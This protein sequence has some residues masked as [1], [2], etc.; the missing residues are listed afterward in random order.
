MWG[1]DSKGG[2][3]MLSC[4]FGCPNTSRH[5]LCVH[6][7]PYL[8]STSVCPPILYVPQMSWELLGG[9]C[10]PHM[11]WGLCKGISISVRHFCVCQYIHCLTVYNSHTSCSPSLWIASLL[12]WML[13]DVC[14]ASCCCSFLCCVFIMSQASATMAMTTSPLVTIGYSGMSSL[15]SMVTM[16]TFLVGFPVTSG[17]HDVL[18]PLLTLR[19][20]GG[21][22]GL[23]TVP[24]QQP[25]SRI[26][27]QTCANYAM[28]PLQVGFSLRVE[29][30]TIC[31]FICLVSVLM[32]A[33]YFQVLYWMLY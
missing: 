18:S 26:P 13:M 11:S 9:I 1:V 31:I 25:P 14:H 29:P 10:T 12:D 8:P 28:G 3:C 20:S 19:H 4:M 27:L 17:Q 6:M 5:P 30:P 22:D 24:Q 23:A 2:I 16:I 7:P 21:V 15:L 33:F 32:Y